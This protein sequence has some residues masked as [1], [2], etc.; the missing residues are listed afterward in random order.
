MVKQL[1]L[2]TFFM[3]LSCVDLHWNKLISI[4]AQMNGENL[5]DNDM[6]KMDFFERCTYLDLQPVLLA[7]HFQNR[8]EMFFKVIAVD[9]PLGKVK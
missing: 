2:P 3:I 4:I 6:G 1:G 5:D 7:R 9:V 8:V